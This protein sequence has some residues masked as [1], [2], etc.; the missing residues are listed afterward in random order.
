MGLCEQAASRPSTAAAI[1]KLVIRIA[2][3]NPTWGHRRTRQT[4]HPIAASTVWHIL[5]A[6]G[7]DPALR[8]VNPAWKRFLIAQARNVLA[9]DFVHVKAVPLRRLYALV[10]IDHSTRRMH[11]T[12]LPIH[13]REHGLTFLDALVML[14]EDQA[15]D[16]V[17]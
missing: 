1:S 15:P 6:A 8:R 3:D 13:G 9:V 16:A 7:T 14:T 17:P 10:V 4:R 5:H 11:H 2:T 12:E